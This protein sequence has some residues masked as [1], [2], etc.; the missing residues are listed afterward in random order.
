MASLLHRELIPTSLA[1]R[2]RRRK[3]CRWKLCL[4]GTVWKMLCF[5]AQAA[6]H[7]VGLT[8]LARRRLIENTRRLHSEELNARLRRI[9]FH[10]STTRSLNSSNED[11]FASFHF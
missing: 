6:V 3:Q 8:I 11:L 1:I 7:R 2:G 9:A 4:I 5:K 10:D